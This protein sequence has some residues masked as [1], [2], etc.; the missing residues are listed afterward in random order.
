[1]T[2]IGPGPSSPPA[3]S[4]L[5]TAAGRYLRWRA[6][7]ERLTDGVSHDRPLPGLVLLA[8]GV[9]LPLF[10]PGYQD[11]YLVTIALMYAV[12]AQAVGVLYGQVGMLSIAHGGLWGIGVYTGV[13]LAAR[14]QW[15][16]WASLVAGL[17]AGAVAAVLVGRPLLRLHGHYFVIV[18]FAFTVLT[19]VVAEAW[20]GVTNGS[21]GVSI[22]EPAFR[23]GPLDIDTQAE[24][25]YLSLGVLTVA[26][27]ISYAMTHGRF[28]RRLAAV[29][30]NPHLT[31]SIGIRVPDL[32][33]KAFVIS[34]AIA[35]AAGVLWA[36]NQAF[37]APETIGATPALLFVVM[38]L[39]G[40]SRS[41]YGPIAGAFIIV[42][43]PEILNLEPLV[44]EMVRGAIVILIVLLMPT[45]IVPTVHMLLR[46]AFGLGRRR[47]TARE[48]AEPAE[49]PPAGAPGDPSVP[50]VS[51]E[52][53]EGEPVLSA[54][55]LAKHFRGIQAL[56]G[57]D[58]HLRAGEVLGLIGPNGSGKSTLLNA[59]AG[60]VRADGGRVVVLGRDVTTTPPSTRSRTGV[61]RTFQER[62]VFPALTVRESMIVAVEATPSAVPGAASAWIADLARLV[63]L[64]HKLDTRARDLSWGETR[65]L[66][67]AIALAQRPALILI[68]EPFA[69]LSPSG[70]QR[71]IDL[72]SAIRRSG[73]AMCVVDHDMGYLLPLCDRVIALDRGELIYEGPVDGV[74]ASEPVR[75]AYFGG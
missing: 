44:S 75:L 48:P 1:M 10:A 4:P 13:L 38:V 24:W 22:F 9:T 71:V 35:A 46:A 67:I 49:A 52:P 70:A 3:A 68:D 50:H 27:V 15:S 51:G 34:G 54:T 36:Y 64:D 47:A 72:L 56:T 73:I 31:E 45:G 25:Y 62:T 59:L 29:R 53:P 21:I 18:G 69:G 63:S 2:A 30:E 8:A 42:Y 26:T 6:A 7:V 17:A 39:L 11:Y 41:I 61:G 20:T 12:V 33:L 74:L 65:L 57:V 43:L 60:R 55:G 37:V 23:F 5:R 32:R 16:V 14:A 28:G 19:Q 40:G 58:L 66:G